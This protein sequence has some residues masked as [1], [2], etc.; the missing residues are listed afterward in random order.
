MRQLDKLFWTITTFNCGT[1][2]GM[3][4]WKGD[5]AEAK[6]TVKSEEKRHEND[7]CQGGLYNSPLLLYDSDDGFIAARFR[8][9]DSTLDLLSQVSAAIDAFPPTKHYHYKGIK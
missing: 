2:L 3:G 5:G 4:A 9:Q 8:L 1:G 7:D 6:I